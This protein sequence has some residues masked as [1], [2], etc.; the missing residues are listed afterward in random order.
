MRM[1][2]LSNCEVIAARQWTNRYL[3]FQCSSDGSLQETGS[4]V[5]PR[6]R[7]GD[8]FSPNPCLC[9]PKSHETGGQRM[10]G[11]YSAPFMVAGTR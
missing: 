1:E 9:R 11:A 6:H 5:R 7:I 10:L 8:S 3:M 2:G 4:A